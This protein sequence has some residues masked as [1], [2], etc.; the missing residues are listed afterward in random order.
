MST[1][2]IV[3]R[4]AQHSSRLAPAIFEL[5]NPIPY[6]LFVGTLIFDVT[7]MSTRNVFWGKGAAWLVTA[8]LIIAIIPRLIN[9]GHVWLQRRRRVSRIEQIDFWL[10]LAG[11]AVAIVNTF[12][13]SRD[14]YAMVPD[15]VILSVITVVLLSI[16]HVAMSMNRVDLAEAVHE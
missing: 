16:A 5:L 12:V 7:Y 6:G 3:P 4:Q 9:L 11:I 1:T 14:A 10:N 8:G 2:P 15:N 13:H